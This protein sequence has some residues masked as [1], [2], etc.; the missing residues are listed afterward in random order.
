M[1]TTCPPP[2]TTRRKRTMLGNTTHTRRQFG[3]SP[4]LITSTSKILEM[5][6]LIM[7]PRPISPQSGCQFAPS[8]FLSC[9]LLMIWMD[10][11]FK[12]GKSIRIK[13]KSLVTPRRPDIW[14]TWILFHSAL[15]NGGGSELCDLLKGTSEETSGASPATSMLFDYDWIL[16]QET[17]GLSFHCPANRWLAWSGFPVTDWCLTL[18]VTFWLPRELSCTFKRPRQ[19]STFMHVKG[20]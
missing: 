12:A 7:T 3:V 17:L 2:C 14:H 1:N 20:L 16:S 6:L 5:A 18:D 8:A 15:D 13:H 10:R 11:R 4:P 19:T 9:V